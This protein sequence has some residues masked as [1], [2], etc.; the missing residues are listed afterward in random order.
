[1][2]IS[3]EKL[4]MLRQAMQEHKQRLE[5]DPEYRRKSEEFRQLVIKS[6]ML[7]GK[8]TDD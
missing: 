4:E 7:M 8:D 3:K 5:T 6:G 2:E 1:M